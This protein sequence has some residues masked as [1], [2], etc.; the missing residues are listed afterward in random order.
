MKYHNWPGFPGGASGKE[1]ACQCRRHKRSRSITVL[2]RSPGEG[3]GM[4]THFSILAWKIL[5]TEEPGSL[6]STGSHRV[7]QDWSDLAHSCIDSPI[8]GKKKPIHV[9]IS[10]AWLRCMLY[11]S[12]SSPHP[13]LHFCLSRFWPFV[14]QMTESPRQTKVINK[15]NLLAYTNKNAKGR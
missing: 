9:L 10:M 1:P 3:H 2:A 6:Q 7:G 8:W 13:S 4:A 14:R 5:W 11:L 12:G 15:G